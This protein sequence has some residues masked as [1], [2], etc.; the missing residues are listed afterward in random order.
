MTDID[1]GAKL[2]ALSEETGLTF[3][4]PPEPALA[5]EILCEGSQRPG[6]VPSKTEAEEIQAAGEK[7]SQATAGALVKAIRSVPK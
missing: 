5:I 6:N 3:T 4:P 2:K 7:F 1:Y